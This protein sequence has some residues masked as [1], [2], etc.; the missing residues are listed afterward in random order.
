MRRVFLCSPYRGAVA[1]NVAL[2]REAGRR[3]LLAGDTVFVPHLYL[4]Q[5]LDDDD[6]REREIGLRAGLAWLPFCDAV[7]VAGDTTEGMRR[8]IAEARAMGIPI[9]GRL[10]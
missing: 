6:P 2:A 10:P 3:I 9:E 7:V 4:P 1:R 5:M 8:E